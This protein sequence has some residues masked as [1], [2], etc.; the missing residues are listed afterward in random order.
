MS[1]GLGLFAHV[2]GAPRQRGVVASVT[3]NGLGLTEYGSIPPAGRVSP[4]DSTD[5]DASP[6]GRSLLCLVLP[7]PRLPQRAGRRTSAR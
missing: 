3:A 4:V 7:S 5:A 6:A 1:V 2:V